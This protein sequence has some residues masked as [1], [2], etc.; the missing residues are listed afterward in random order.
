MP[1]DRERQSA[2]LIPGSVHKSIV[3]LYCIC[4]IVYF[5][6]FPPT[7]V[8]ISQNAR[9]ASVIKIVIESVLITNVIVFVFA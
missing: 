4:N 2:W 5:V 7:F 9:I 1:A 8:F 6:L 3:I